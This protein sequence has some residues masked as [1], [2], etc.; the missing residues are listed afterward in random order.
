MSSWLWWLGEV[1]LAKGEGYSRR[2]DA[3]AGRRVSIKMDERGMVLAY[4]VTT[5]S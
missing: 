4:L 5:K 3:A 1:G 2:A